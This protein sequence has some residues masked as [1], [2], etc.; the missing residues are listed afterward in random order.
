MIVGT[1]GTV[2][3]VLTVVIV[4]KEVTVNFFFQLHISQ[5]SPPEMPNVKHQGSSVRGFFFFFFFFFLDMISFFV[6]VQNIGF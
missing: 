5:D 4:V 2:L 1:V 6:V 3:T